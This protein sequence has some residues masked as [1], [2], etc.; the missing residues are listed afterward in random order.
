MAAHPGMT[1]FWALSNWPALLQP[2][3]MSHDQATVMF[4]AGNWNL[5]LLSGKKKKKKGH[6]G[7]WICLTTTAK[8][9]VKSGT[10]TCPCPLWEMKMLYLF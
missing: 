2:F 4:F 5:Y 1:A 7:Q 9:I 10:V 6:C 8:K 3:T